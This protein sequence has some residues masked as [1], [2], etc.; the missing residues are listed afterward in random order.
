MTVRRRVLW[1]LSVAMCVIA[2][3]GL[4]VVRELRIMRRNQVARLYEDGLIASS[5]LAA[6][7]AGLV[8]SGEIPCSDEW[9]GCA[10]MWGQR[11][12]GLGGKGDPWGNPW[13]C[14]CGRAALV[15]EAAGPDGIFD[16]DDDVAGWVE[17]SEGVREERLPDSGAE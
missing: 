17:F 14:S 4:L 2:A 12:Y 15:V 1:V 9:K 13:M 10:A 3:I 6:A 8:R 5:A 16:N 11:D 7:M